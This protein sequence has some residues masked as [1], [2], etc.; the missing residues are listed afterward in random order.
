MSRGRKPPRP[1]TPLRAL[2]WLGALAAF[3]FAFDLLQ[4]LASYKVQERD[5]R[6]LV[7]SVRRPVK[8]SLLW[9]AHGLDGGPS[10][11]GLPVF[12]FHLR[13]EDQAL[14]EEHMRRVQLIGTHDEVTR[15][16][17]EGRMT[18]EGQTFD[19]RIKLRGRQY[20]HVVP[21]RPSLLVSLRHGR[22]YRGASTFNLVEPFDKTVDQ[23]FLGESEE[24]GLVG[25]DQTLGVIAFE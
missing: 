9:V 25:W 12:D 14:L 10:T 11:E 18:V 23:V 13:A 1:I 20:Y 7:R 3:L 6:S 19:V 8:D 5:R 21:P 4:R 24:Q 16:W 22:T 2:L 17:V 15:S